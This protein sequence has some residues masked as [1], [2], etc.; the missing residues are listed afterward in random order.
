MYHLSEIYY[1]LN[2][3]VVAGQI[4]CLSGNTGIGTAAHAH[5][6]FVRIDKTGRVIKDE[7]GGSFDPFDKN[8][9]ELIEF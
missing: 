1:R 7:Y 3:K 8:I 6:E 4:P 2:Q 5:I 9:V